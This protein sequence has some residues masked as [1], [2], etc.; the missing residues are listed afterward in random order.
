ML[1]VTESAKQKLKEML[2]D[3]VEDPQQSLR[4]TANTSGQ[5]GLSIDME[6][7]GDQVVEHEGSK[8]LLVEEELATR[9][10]GITLDTEDT[11]EGPKLAI[12]RE[13]KEAGS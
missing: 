10:E 4:L 9:L 1:S 12:R 3:K 11:P 7:T 13:S 6:A 2:S 5:L 8:V